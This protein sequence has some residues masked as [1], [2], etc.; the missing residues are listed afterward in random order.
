[1]AHFER[2]VTSCLR[3]LGEVAFAQDKPIWTVQLFAAASA[4][5]GPHERFNPVGIEKSSCDRVLANVHAR[6]DKNAFAEAWKLGLAMTLPQVLAAATSSCPS[7]EQDSTRQQAATAPPSPL[8]VIHN[9]LTARQV[10]VLS[11]LAQGLSNAQIAERLVVSPYTINRHVQSIYNKL[12]VNSRSAATR[13]AL[14]HHLI[15]ED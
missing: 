13:Y 14:E 4:I 12:G 1:M 7:P 11:L 6:L 9:D 15:T 3:G 2:T 5:S 10:E 8:A